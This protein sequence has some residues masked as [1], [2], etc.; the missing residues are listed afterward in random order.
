MTYGFEHRLLINGGWRESA[1]REPSLNPS[2]L[3]DTLGDYCWAGT[4]EVE[5]AIAAARDAQ[6]RWRRGNVQAR[7]D[8]LLSIGAAEDQARFR[9]PGSLPHGRAMEVM[10]DAGIFVSSSLY[11]PFGLAVAEAARAAIP[12][13]L[14][15]IPT[16]RELWDGAA[17]FFPADDAGALADALN[18]LAGD[19]ALR[20]HLGDAA[21]ERSHCYSPEAQAQAAI[22]FLSGNSAIASFA[23][24]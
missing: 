9:A 16:F 1:R 15:D 13:V 21:Q 5:A 6:P 14:A 24:S 8:L 22:R 4:D 7:A 23:R 2:D 10:R 3:G 11:E 12:L 20:R 17:L 19:P 18:R